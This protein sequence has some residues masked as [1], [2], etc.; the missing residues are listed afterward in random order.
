MFKEQ[1]KKNVLFYS[2]GI[3]LIVN[4]LIWTILSGGR[5]FDIIPPGETQLPEFAGNT[6]RVFGPFYMLAFFTI[7]T[8]FFTGITTTIIGFKNNSNKAKNWFFGSVVLITITFLVYWA[9]LAPL[10]EL[11]KWSDPYFVISTLFTHGINPIIGFVVLFMIKNEFILD[12]KIIGW[13][14]LF[15]SIYVVFHSFF[16]SAGAHLKEVLDDDGNSTGEYT[17][18]FP[19]I[20][21]FLDVRKILFINGI[22]KYPWLVVIINMICFLIAPLIAVGLSWIWAKSLRLKSTNNSYYKW[23]DRIKEKINN[24]KEVSKN[25][26]I[27]NEN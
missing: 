5:W 24:K 3:F 27:V 20:Y 7:Q 16:Y 13:I 6:H 4:T 18:V 1:N 17:I 8:N 14:C 22:E 11:Y 15:M 9:I 23:M 19:Y 10:T 2:L 12:K 25:I 26:D 21:G